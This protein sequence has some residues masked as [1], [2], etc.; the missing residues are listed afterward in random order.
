[1]IDLPEKVTINLRIIVK[2]Q[3]HIVD[4]FDKKKGLSCPYIAFFL[5]TY[6]RWIL[7][8]LIY[9]WG[10]IWLFIILSLEALYVS[11]GHWVIRWEFELQHAHLFGKQF[12]NKIYSLV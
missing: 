2:K 3:L 8:S 11:K 10:N 6:I 12:L 1:M 9:L 7:L 4:L 5:L